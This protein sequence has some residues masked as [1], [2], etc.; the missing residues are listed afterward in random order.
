MSLKAE[1]T[2][3]PV[4]AAEEGGVVFVFDRVMHYHRATFQEIERRL[5]V[6][7]IPFRVLSAQDCV[8]SVGRVAERSK[9]VSRHEHFHLSERKVGSFQLRY[10]HGMIERLKS[11]APTVVV[12]TSH[13]GTLSEWLLLCW[14]KRHG[15]RRVAWQCGYDYNPGHLKRFILRR[16]VPMFDFHLCYHSHARTY[17]IGYGAGASQTLVMHNTIDQRAIAAGDRVSARRA[18][19]DRHPDLKHK[20]LVLYVGAVLA[21]KRLESVFDALAALA[22]PDIMFVLVGDGSHLPALKSRYAD[23]TDWLSTGQIVDGVGAYFDAAD[24]FVLPGTGGLAINE[25]MAHGVPVIS[26]YADGSADDLVVDGVTGFRLRGETAAEL[27]QRLDDVLSDPDRARKMG[28]AGE[29][30]IR[31]HL[32]FEAFID[33]VVGVLEAQHALARRGR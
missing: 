23:R 19:V 20:K 4:A 18:L 26:G 10:Q 25:A 14:A 3:S 7:R 33:R 11:Y 24:V 28:A 2:L 17:A 8:G 29:E 1:C 27:A 21:E 30:R 9:V 15:V 31:G 6:R 13:S 5:A 22:R 16:F 12:S 32:S